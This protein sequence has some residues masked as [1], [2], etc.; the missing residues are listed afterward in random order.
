M[1][2]L[3][4]KNLQVKAEGKLILRGLDLEVGKGEV[5]A[6]MGPNG[7]G[8]STL[9]KALMGDPEFE[10]V[11][12]D[13][14]EKIT[15]HDN[16]AGGAKSIVQMNGQNLLTMTPNERAEAG[17]FL[18][19]QNPIEVPGVRVETFLREAHRVRFAG[20]DNEIKGALD[21]RKFVKKLAGELSVDPEF[22]KRGLN[23]N[24]SGGEKKR[25]E[26]LQ[27][28]LLKPE[29]AILDETDS[30]LDIDALRAV[31]KG[32]KKVIADNKTGMIV[33]THY[34]RILEYLKPDFVHVMKDGKIVESGG[35]EVV[36]RLEEKGYQE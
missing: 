32:V 3:I 21:F 33:I 22:L 13:G 7:A 25:L 9:A 6:L 34:K 29:F 36:E 31:A 16:V 24:F 8:K 4:I 27:M 2:K 15:G 17:L 1:K 26:I 19:F 5:H 11:E 35:K 18:S 20:T 30:G 14:D 28:A 10:V 23:E 12:G